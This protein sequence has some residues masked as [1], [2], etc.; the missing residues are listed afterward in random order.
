MVRAMGIFA[1]LDGSQIAHLFQSFKPVK[2]YKGAAVVS[3]GDPGDRFFV[4]REGELDVEV[5]AAE[6][7]KQIAQLARG[8]YFGEMALLHDAPRAATVRAVSDVEL[9]ALDRAEFLRAIQGRGRAH[10]E[11]AS[12]KR[13][14]EL[15]S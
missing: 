9:L 11:E 13:G 7:K 12:A 5:R 3:Q 10:L 15:A 2:A 4:V 6:G 1:E 14:E 8:D